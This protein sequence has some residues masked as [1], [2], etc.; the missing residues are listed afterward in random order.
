VVTEDVLVRAV[1]GANG[2]LSAA[3]AGAAVSI[4]LW[5]AVAEGS[6][7]A[8]DR[9][10]RAL[11]ADERILRVVVGDLL[12]TAAGVHVFEKTVAHET[13]DAGRAGGGSTPSPER[14]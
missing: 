4:L 11:L 12:S 2:Y 8:G 6:R 1:C 9:I 14:E 10:A 3:P 7:A 13:P 5:G